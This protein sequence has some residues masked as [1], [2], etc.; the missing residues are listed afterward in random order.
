MKYLDTLSAI[1]AGTAV[2]ST[3][4]IMQSS[5]LALEGHEVNDIAREVTVLVYGINPG[6]GVLIAKDQNTYYV[7]TANHVVKDDDEYA[8][9]TSDKK[10]HD[11]DYSKIRRLP[12][13]DLAV[14][15][16]TSEEDYKVANLANS[17]N[18]TEGQTVFI[19][20]W[21]NP[22]TSI[23]K[24]IRQFT[25][26]EVS[27]RP[28]EALEGGYQIVYTNVTRA[29]MSGAPVFDTSGRVIGI[30]GQGDGEKIYKE[31]QKKLEQSGLSQTL[32]TNAQLDGFNL[33]IPINTFLSLAPQNGIYLSLKVE[34][35]PPESLAKPYISTN[36][37]DERDRINNINDTLD[38][39]NR[40][41]NTIDN[42][43]RILPF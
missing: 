14:I 36:E 6:S 42:I 34:N 10:A 15:E 16:F 30:H 33:G 2:T 28:D 23:K 18:I 9:L 32:I 29:G 11:V 40:S 31:E 27:A 13:T 3:L 37:V 39:I 20:G 22:G 7:L 38:T 5:V 12:G 43:R 35:S 26:G 17:D 41:I 8:I 1:I 4:V 24:R 25:S 21:P 19:S